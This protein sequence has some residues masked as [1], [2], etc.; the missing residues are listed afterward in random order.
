M[1]LQSIYANY[2]T[3]EMA[4]GK[5]KKESGMK[6]DS[7]SLEEKKKKLKISILFCFSERNLHLKNKIGVIKYKITSE[8]RAG[9]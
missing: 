7:A 3:S 8:E 1:K 5:G 6:R 2:T 4:A 9:G